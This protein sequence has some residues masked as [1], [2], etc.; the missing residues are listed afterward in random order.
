MNQQGFSDGCNVSDGKRAN[1]D[2]VHIP[3][4]EECS[5]EEISTNWVPRFN[6]K[7]TLYHY[8]KRLSLEEGTRLRTP[9]AWCEAGEDAGQIEARRLGAAASNT[10]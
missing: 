8:R 9:L 5:L 4:Q 6:V 7:Y 3:W 2:D 10:V 1:I